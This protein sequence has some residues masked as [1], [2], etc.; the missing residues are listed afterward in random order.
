MGAWLAA[1]NITPDLVLVSGA[2]RTRE[3]WALFAPELGA[4]GTAEMR[5]DLYDTDAAGIIAVITAVRPNVSTLLIIGHNSGLEEAA[6]KMVGHGDD[7]FRRSMAAKFPTAA[8]AIIDFDIATW[9]AVVPGSGRLVQ[10]VTPKSFG[11]S[12]DAAH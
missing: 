5:D 8:L 10:F 6:T 9:A 1:Q 3:T 2:V 11:P 7:G 12:A 4:G